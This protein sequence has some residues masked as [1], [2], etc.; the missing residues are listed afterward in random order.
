MRIITFAE[1]T[2]ALL[3]GAKT[4]TRRE[5]KPNYART[6]AAGEVL[7]AWDKNPRTGKGKRVGTIRLTAA[8]VLQRANEIPPSDW[9]AEGFA[10]M[11]HYGLTLFDGAT[12]TE[13]F[14]G[15]RNAPDSVMLWVVRFK[16]IGV[17][18]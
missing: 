9:E 8:P 4:C 13:V 3:A 16:L 14:N 11:Q 5:W 18:Q 10:Y 2:A 17:T 6:F 7:Q 15:W 12:T 1:T